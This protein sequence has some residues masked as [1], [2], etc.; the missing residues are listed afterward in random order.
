MVDIITAGASLTAAAIVFTL[1]SQGVY[2]AEDWI[3]NKMHPKEDVN[4]KLNDI[5]KNLNKKK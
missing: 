3:Y 1:V 5:I 2:K 4:A